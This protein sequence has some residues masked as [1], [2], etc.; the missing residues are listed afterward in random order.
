MQGKGQDSHSGIPNCESCPGFLKLFACSE[1]V[2][3]PKGPLR[4]S[5]LERSGFSNVLEL[6]G[7]CHALSSITITNQL[8]QAP[9]PLDRCPPPTFVRSNR[10]RRIVS[11]RGI[12]MSLAN[13]PAFVFTLKRIL[14]VDQPG[15]YFS[16]RARLTRM[17]FCYLPFCKSSVMLHRSHKA[18]SK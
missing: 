2:E 3:P 1:C 10:Y 8:L 9:R 15:C 18:C 11:F 17:V 4:S 7:I 14:S 6:D 16:C 12:V 5:R 13:H